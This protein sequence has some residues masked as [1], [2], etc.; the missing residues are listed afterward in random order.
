M[1]VRKAAGV[2]NS[3]H[4]F[5]RFTKAFI[6]AWFAMVMGS[7]IVAAV[8]LEVAGESGFIKS[9]AI[10]VWVIAAL[11]AVLSVTFVSQLV[12]FPRVFVAGLSTIHT[13]EYGCIPMG[14]MAVGAGA[15]KIGA[16]LLHWQTLVTIGVALYAVGTAGGLLITVGAL[17]IAMD[18]PLVT[19]NGPSGAWLVPVV[20]PMVSAANGV[21]VISQLPVELQGPLLGIC[22]ALFGMTI[23]FA[24]MMTGMLVHRL[25]SP[26]NGFTPDDVPGLW[27]ILG[28]VGQSMTA[29]LGLS[30]SAPALALGA[31]SD[32]RL[33]AAAFAL[34][35]LGFGM[36]WLL[37]CILLVHGTLMKRFSMAWWSFVFPIGTL[38]NGVF[39]L[40]LRLDAA[41]IWILGVGLTIVLV[42]M[43]AGVATRTIT[44]AGRA[45]R[46][47]LENVHVVAGR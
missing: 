38:A 21:Q 13:L 30:G 20:P 25:V 34:A 47:P 39:A 41:P 44:L 15:L 10:A 18:R 35:D 46:S 43:W 33:A 3:S 29:S 26:G 6:P 16:N 5:G 19:Q 37:L 4:A 31:G 45:L 36:L 27:I 11:L 42:V 8:L 12:N 22:I 1:L 32:L 23:V 9:F 24:V 7:G 17:A 40:S 28:V 14:I 2:D